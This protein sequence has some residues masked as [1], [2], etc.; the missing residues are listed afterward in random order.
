MF[1]GLLLR[2]FGPFTTLWSGLATAVAGGIIGFVMT[3]EPPDIPARVP[4]SSFGA[5]LRDLITILYRKPRIAAGGIVKVINIGGIMGMYVMYVPYLTREI[6]VPI[7]KAV[8]MFTIMGITGVP[9]NLLWGYVSDRL[10]W[11]NTIQWIACPIN[12]VAIAMLYLVP[13]WLGPELVPIAC[14][15]LFWGF[16]TSAFSPLSALLTGIASDEVGN[17][18]SV[19]NFASGVSIFIGPALVGALLGVCGYGGI[20]IVLVLLYVLACF[21]M[22]YVQLPDRAR[23]SRAVRERAT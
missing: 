16:G 23:S 17:A 4:N 14:I 9:G 18:I 3:R 20:I 1:A 8:Y 7:D 5:G 22:T 2:R 15:M 21:L 12:A 13:R 11:A 10:G 19:V 6:G